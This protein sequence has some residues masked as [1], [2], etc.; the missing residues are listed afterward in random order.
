MVYLRRIGEAVSRPAA[1]VCVCVAILV[2]GQSRAW[3]QGAAGEQAKIGPSD[4]ADLNGFGWSVSVSGDTAIVGAPTKSDS[5]QYSGAAYIFVRDQ[6]GANLG[7]G[8][9]LSA[10]DAGPNHQFGRSVSISGDTAIVGAVGDDDLG[11]FTGS[12]Y[13]FERNQGGP[14]A[15]GEVTKLTASAGAASSNFGESVSI[16]GDIAIVGSPGEGY[17]GPST[18]LGLHLRP[19]SRR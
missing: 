11:E 18:G 6:G 17:A 14:N 1:A 4:P 8:V 9:K 13:I 7:R 19:Q 2:A 5:G 3:A 16:A 15:W 10:H 12:A